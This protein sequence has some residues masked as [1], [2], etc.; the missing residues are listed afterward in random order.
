MHIAQQDWEPF[1]PFV[2]TR[3]RNLEAH[4]AVLDDALAALQAA[5]AAEQ[6][7]ETQQ[8]LDLAAEFAALKAQLPDPSIAAG[9]ET[10][11]ANIVARTAAI[12]AGDPGPQPD[13]T[14]PVDPTI[15]VDP[16][17]PPTP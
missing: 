11:V 7:A 2:N 12:A 15:S 1:I 9:M 13:S 4:V 17:A 3:F 16:N 14:V 8:A 10:V 6:T 5:D